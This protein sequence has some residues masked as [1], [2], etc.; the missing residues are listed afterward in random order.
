MFRILSLLLISLLVGLL[1]ISTAWAIDDFLLSINSMSKFEAGHHPFVDGKTIDSQNN[2]VPGVTIQVVFPSETV[3]TTSNSDGKFSAMT[4]IPAELGEYTVTAY[5]KKDDKHGSAQLSYTVTA[6]KY[7]HSVKSSKTENDTRYDPFSRMILQQIEEQQSEDTKKQ[8]RSEEQ[9]RIDESR[10]QSE[11]DLQNDL[12]TSEKKQEF[13]SPRNAFLRFLSDVDNS[14][15]NI[16][17]QQFLFTEKITKE[18]QQ[19]KQNALEEGMSSLEATRIF[20]QEAAVTQKEIIDHNK[21]ISIT[22]GNSTSYIQDQFN[23]NGKMSRE[24]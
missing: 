16:F 19:A 17:W 6:S 21:N 18:A 12:K 24:E 14:F 15:K 8:E 23:E 22:Y 13:N 5:A 9:R 1:G 7:A 11:K 20:Q 4:Q 3:T 10:I 2:P